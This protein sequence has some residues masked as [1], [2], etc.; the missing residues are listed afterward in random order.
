MRWMGGFALHKL[1]MRLDLRLRRLKSW[2][3]R[4]GARY[5][6]DWGPGAQDWRWSGEY[7]KDLRARLGRGCTCEGGGGHVYSWAYE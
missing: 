4:C 1:G 6:S 5:W 3:R 7:S 2:R